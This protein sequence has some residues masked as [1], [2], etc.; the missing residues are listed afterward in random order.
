MTQEQIN[1]LFLLLGTKEFEI[2]QLHRALAEA[3]MKLK[4]LAQLEESK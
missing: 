4:K 1:A 3:E 2:M